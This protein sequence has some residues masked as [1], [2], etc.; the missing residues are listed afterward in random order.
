MERLFALWIEIRRATIKTSETGRARLRYSDWGL[1]VETYD[2]DSEGVDILP[3]SYV[4]PDLVTKLLRKAW[5]SRLF[6][7]ED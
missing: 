5:I 6:Y 1:V 3:I 7:L 4:N 2:T